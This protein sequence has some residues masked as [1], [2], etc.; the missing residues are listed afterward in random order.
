MVCN[1]I[2]AIKDNHMPPE[3]IQVT[4]KKQTYYN[5]TQTPPNEGKE[6]QRMQLV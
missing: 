4:Y 1:H 3:S 5:G 6:A 2:V